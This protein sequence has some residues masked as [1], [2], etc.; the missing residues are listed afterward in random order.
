MALERGELRETAE[1]RKSVSLHTYLRKM[2]G[3]SSKEPNFRIGESLVSAGG[4]LIAMTIISVMAVSLG[5]P[6]ALG[7]IGASCLLVF[8][9][10]QGPFSQPRQIIGGHVLST[11]A[12]LS[13]WDLFGRSHVTIGITLA[14]VLLL[15]IITQ[16]MHPPA[17]ASAI[18]AINS[19]AG[20]GFLFTIFISAL[21][22]VGISVL[23][24]NLFKD[25]TYPKKWT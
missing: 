5:Y 10:H 6:M 23:Y 20:W 4:G 9:A 1:I 19:Q 13:I 18:V 22:V 25:R 17:A 7:P 8:A 14:V 3:D 2:K 24:N 21:I 15:M 12:A 16:S 11:G